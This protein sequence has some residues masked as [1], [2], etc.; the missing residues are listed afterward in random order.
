[1]SRIINS[2]VL[3]APCSQDFESSDHAQNSQT[4]DVW[5]LI[6]EHCHVVAVAQVVSETAR[7]S[8]V[9]IA[10]FALTRQAAAMVPMTAV[11]EPKL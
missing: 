3:A 6:A 9:E 2:G 11:D 10:Y 7:Y 8:R 1:M 4:S 5:D